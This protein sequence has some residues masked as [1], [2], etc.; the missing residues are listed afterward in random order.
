[1]SSVSSLN[2]AVTAS[3]ANLP[4]G[5]LQHKRICFYGAG[6]MAE[7]VIRG[8]I[9]T[10]AAPAAQIAVFNRQ[11]RQRLEAL[12]EQYGVQPAYDS[13]AQQL[14]LQQA[15]IIVLG[16]KP[17][18]AVEAIHML[19]STLRPGQLLVSLIAGLNINT[20]E[21]L[22]GGSAAVVRTMPNTSC[23]IGL[24]VTGISFSSAVSGEQRQL[25]LAMFSATGIASIVDEG[26]LDIVTGVSGSGPAYIYY[27]MEAM[28]QG[29]VSGGL[30]PEQARD[31]TVQ[32]VLGAARMVQITGENP[33]DLRRKVTSPN[34]T[35]EAAIKTLDEHGFAA[36]V[37]AA[38]LRAAERAG[39][40][41]ALLAADVQTKQ[42][43]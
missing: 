43:S 23:T 10:G 1:M 37:Q 31:L 22:L 15:D 40:L 16:M 42:N 8:L 29:A 18:D 28:I 33:A 9:D 30:T 17:K 26:L 36:G 5:G 20:I 24:G 21:L 41:G 11:N 35:T 32:T 13:E 7:A 6:A 27:M 34:G 4:D 25:A 3:G 12:Q 14:A 38:V 2:D 19:R 39:E